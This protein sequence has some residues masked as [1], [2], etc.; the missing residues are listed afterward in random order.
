MLNFVSE[1]LVL[2]Q[3]RGIVSQWFCFIR[4]SLFGPLGVMA[5]KFAVYLGPIIVS[6]SSAEKSN[7][8]LARRIRRDTVERGRDYAK[9]VKPDFDDFILPSKKYA[10]IIIPRG[11]ENRVAIYLIVQHIRTKLGQHNLCKIYPNLNTKGMHTLIRDR[12]ISKHDFFSHSDRLIRL[13]VEHGLGYLS[14]TE[15]QVITP[16]GLSKEEEKLFHHLNLPAS[17]SFIHVLAEYDRAYS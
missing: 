12:D 8:R 1:C 9:F 7:V 11:V 5:N 15:K 13:V 16:T 3:L 10:D 4:L 17:V 2:A 6:K 14:F